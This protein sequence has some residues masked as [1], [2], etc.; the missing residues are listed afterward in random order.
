M[1]VELRSSAPNRC[2][3]SCMD[4]ATKEVVLGYG[5]QRQVFALCGACAKTAAAILRPAPAHPA[6]SAD[7]S[8]PR[9]TFPEGVDVPISLVGWLSHH[10][11]NLST[12]WTVGVEEIMP[13]GDLH[14]IQRSAQKRLDVLLDT[15]SDHVV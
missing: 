5:N 8:D 4:P 11:R 9:T 15:L 12:A 1:A 7:E 13:A 14:R 2:C 3:H 10:L 6:R